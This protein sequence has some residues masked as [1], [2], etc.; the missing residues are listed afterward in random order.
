MTHLR[1]LTSAWTGTDDCAGGSPQPDKIGGV[2]PYAVSYA[3]DST[4]NRIKETKHG[5]GGGGRRGPL[6]HPTRSAGGKQ[7][8]A[9]QAVGADLFEYDAAG[10][11]T[12]RKVAASDQTL[13]W[14][15]EGNLESVTEAG[16][17]TSF[18]YD[19]DGNRLLRKTPTDATLYVDDMELRFDFAKDVVEQTRFY[20]IN[21]HPIAVRTNDNQV[22]LLANDHQGTAQAAVNAGNGEL[23]YGGRRP[24]GENRGLAP[25]MVAGAARIRRRHAGCD[26][27]ARPPRRPRVRPR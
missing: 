26:D 5:W 20:T 10:N 17:T 25:A 16:K 11:T 23:P 24:F 6:L 1:R 14:D 4:G 21:D 15:A 18:V 8:H 22:Y 27:R 9:L 13:A 3:Y 19:A 2:A 7:P 12:R